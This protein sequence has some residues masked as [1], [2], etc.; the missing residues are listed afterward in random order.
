MLKSRNVKKHAIDGQWPA[1]VPRLN[2]QNLFPVLLLALFFSKCH[3]DVHSQPES[4]HRNIS[5]ILIPAAGF[6]SHVILP[7]LSSYNQSAGSW[8]HNQHIQ[9]HQEP[10]PEDHMTRTCFVMRSR[11]LA[12]CFSNGQK[13]LIFGADLP[14]SSTS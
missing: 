3:S 5:D 4:G 6:P 13:D 1:T 10:G 14:L 9:M 8:H 12:F 11:M 7:S 2:W